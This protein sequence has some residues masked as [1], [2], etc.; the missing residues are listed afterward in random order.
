M[1]AHLR[2]E[3]MYGLKAGAFVNDNIQVEGSFGYMSHFESRFAPTTLDQSFGILPRTVYGLLYDLNGV[4]NFG[5]QP[6]FGT[7]ISPYVT[8]GIGG[9]STVVRHANAALIGGQFYRIDS[10]TRAPVLNPTRTVV[11]HDNSAFFSLNY[12][13]GIKSLKMWGPM[14]FRVDVRGR[15]FPNFRGKSMTWPEAT[16]GLT[17][18]IGER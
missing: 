4:W 17:F 14:G 3:G 18:T 11:V 6:I 5:Q 7:R 10:G 8:G 2:D 1:T 16:A 15:T 9:L 13:A 12:G